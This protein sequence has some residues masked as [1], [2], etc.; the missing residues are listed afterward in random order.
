MRLYLHCVLFLIVPALAGYGQEPK[1]PFPQHNK[2]KYFGS[3]IYPEVDSNQMMAVVSNIYKIWKDEFLKDN[4]CDHSSYILS[5]SGGGSNNRQEHCV[6][7]A[8][9]YGMMITV[10][11]AEKAD[12]GSQKLFDRLFLYV[13]QH[14]S[15]TDNDRYTSNRKKYSNKSIYIDSSLMAWRQVSECD[16]S[17][18]TSATDGDLDITYSLL[19]A[20]A[21]W[22]SNGKFNYLKEARTILRDIKLK[23]IHPD[24]HTFLLGNSISTDAYGSWDS[25]VIR[26]SDFMPSHL[27]EFNLADTDADKSVWTEAI[28]S[29]YFIY[30]RI[31]EKLSPDYSLFPDFIDY[32]FQQI[33]LP[34]RRIELRKYDSTFYDNA[35]RVPWR[36]GMDYVLNGNPDAYK[37][38]GK[39]NNGM[40]QLTGNDPNNIHP[41]GYTL[42]GDVSTL[43]QIDS[44]RF[45]YY[46]PLAVSAMIDKKYQTWLNRLWKLVSRENIIDD[47]VEYYDRTLQLLTLI[48]LSGNYWTPSMVMR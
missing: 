20:N 6:S 11:M 25:C 8:M 2:I 40:I 47:H 46:G 42:N 28:N 36:I 21:Q 3:V 15:V 23:D 34:R 44:T 27:R 14:P 48:V 1:F 17:K 43:K 26:T 31:Q 16:T 33:N 19:L 22:G 10:L 35:C 37:I 5:N 41:G 38:L 39:F 7:E 45:S 12:S 32:S 30:R 4:A 9:G 18:E 13:K 29:N 24:H